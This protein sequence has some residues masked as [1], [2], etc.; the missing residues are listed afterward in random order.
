MDNGGNTGSKGSYVMEEIGMVYL[1][2]H[3]SD[4]EIVVAVC[5]EELLGKTLG[6]DGYEFYVD[7][8]FYGGRR[9]SISEALTVI[10]SSTIANLVGKK[11]V[12]AAVKHKLVHK[13]AIVYISG[14]PHAQIIKFT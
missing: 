4:T 10:E 12:S 2:E 13:D 1:K 7:P 6:G 9:M 11:I 5:D 8:V 3:L 14:V